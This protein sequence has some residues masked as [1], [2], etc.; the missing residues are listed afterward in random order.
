[1][2]KILQIFIFVLY[3]ME[4]KSAGSTYYCLP[5]EKNPRIHICMYTDQLFSC[6]LERVCHSVKSIKY[7]VPC[8]GAIF[9]FHSTT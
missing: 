1:V 9:V 5:L 6:A 2:S 7:G 3:V 8:S 4:K